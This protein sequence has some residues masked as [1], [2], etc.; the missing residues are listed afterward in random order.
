MDKEYSPLSGGTKIKL[1]ASV[2]AEKN[3]FKVRIIRN[4]IPLFINEQRM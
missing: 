4:K 1:I 2:L 3:A